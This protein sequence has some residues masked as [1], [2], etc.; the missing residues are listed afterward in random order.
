MF[1]DRPKAWLVLERR[2][3]LKKTIY[4]SCKLKPMQCKSYLVPLADKQEYY[5]WHIV[6]QFNTDIP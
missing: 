4:N 6:K 2:F 5:E 3:Y 1:A